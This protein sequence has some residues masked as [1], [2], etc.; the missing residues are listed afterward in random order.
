VP[1]ADMSKKDEAAL[2]RSPNNKDMVR[3]REKEGKRNCYAR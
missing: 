2:M 1:G 3:R